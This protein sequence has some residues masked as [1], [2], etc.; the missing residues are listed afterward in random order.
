MAL[1]DHAS[2][3]NSMPVDFTRKRKSRRRDGTKNVAETLAKWKEYNEKMD[4]LDD[5]GKS[6]RKV[7][8][9]GSKKGCMKGKGGPENAR[10]KYRG[11]RQR[12][13]GKW[14]AEIREPNRGSRLWLGTFGTAIEAALAYDEAARAMYGPCARLNLPNYRASQE[15]SKEYSLL[16]TTSGSDSTTTSSISDVCAYK[17]T[18]ITPIVKKEEGDCE[19]Y[20]TVNRGASHLLD[21]GTPMSTMK[22]EVKEEQGGSEMEQPGEPNL[23]EDVSSGQD[24]PAKLPS[25]VHA[26]PGEDM[27]DGLSLDEMFDVDALL[28]ALD[29]TPFDIF[30]H[31]YDEIQDGNGLAGQAGCN[32]TLASDSLQL[33]NQ[34][35]KMVGSL[36]HVEQMPPQVD[37]YG[38]EFLLPE[39]QEDSNMALSDLGFLDLDA[40]LGH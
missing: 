12:T 39:R 21:V 17:D 2:N 6:A 7:P 35:A 38:L 40:E 32:G 36:H 26:K 28:S 33:Q 5:E 24:Q 13:W 11:V 16:P 10:F 15:S 18:K 29:S 3:F 19:S 23:K 20:N 9:K 37:D 4:S 27:T 30:G 8:A 34:H 22:E 31:R 1:L 25:K 14:V